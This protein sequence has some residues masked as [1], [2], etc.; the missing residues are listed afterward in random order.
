M[1]KFPHGCFIFAKEIVIICSPHPVIDIIKVVND[2]GNDKLSFLL[3]FYR[4]LSQTINGSSMSVQAGSYIYT[5]VQILC[6]E[7]KNH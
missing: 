3:Y 2:F 7:V 6:V 1:Q 5:V 4:T